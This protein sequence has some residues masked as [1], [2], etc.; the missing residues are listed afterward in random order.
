[1]VVVVRDPRN[2]VISEHRMRTEVYHRD[3]ID[4]LNVFIYQRLEV[5]CVRLIVV[6]WC[7]VLP[8]LYSIPV[9]C[10]RTHDTSD[11]CLDAVVCSFGPEVASLCAL[12]RCPISRGVHVAAA[13]V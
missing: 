10:Y 6:C 13:G 1:M 7:E 5:G 4:E 9:V 11:R 8:C 2:V 12:Q 3:I